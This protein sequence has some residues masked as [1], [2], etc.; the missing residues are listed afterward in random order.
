MCVYI[1]MHAKFYPILF[2]EIAKLVDQLPAV[3]GVHGPPFGTK[4]EGP[5]GSSNGEVDISLVALSNLA[6]I[7]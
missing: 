4:L 3:G 5:L 1:N 2:N 6:R 7:R